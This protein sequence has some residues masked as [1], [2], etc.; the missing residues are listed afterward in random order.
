MKRIHAGGLRATALTLL[1]LLVAVAR[2]ATAG[3]KLYMWQAKSPT[4]TVTMVGSIHVGQADFFPLT[5]AYEQAF[6]AAP[7]LAVEVDMTDP[8]VLQKSGTLMLER[9]MLPGDETLETRLEPEVYNRLL[10]HAEK[11]GTPLIMFNKLKPG[12]VALVLVMEEY[13]KQGFDPELGIDKHF[14]DAAKAANKEVRS[15]ETVEDQLQIFFD[16]D[17][18]LDDLMMTEFLDQMV[19][20]KAMTEEMIGY[21]QAGDADGLDRFLQSQMGEGPEMEAFYRK[22]LDDRNVGMAASIEAFLAGDQDVFVVVGA[23]HFAGEKGI[24]ALLRGKGLEVGQ[25]TR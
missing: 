6:A 13:K 2:T 10:L 4:A 24:V 20:V 3:E 16:I 21:W 18:T 5:A 12:I 14:L 19:D 8:A 11:N 9:G 1:L 17:D 7:V 22:L 15:L 25:V 23:G